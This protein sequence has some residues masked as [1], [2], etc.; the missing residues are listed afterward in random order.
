[1]LEHQEQFTMAKHPFTC[2]FRSV[3]NDWTGLQ[4]IYVKPE[5]WSSESGKLKSNSGEAKRINKLLEGFK[6]KA[7]DYQRELMTEGKE[8]T[9]ENMKAKWYKTS[10]EKPSMLKEIFRQHNEQMKALINQEFLH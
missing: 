3:L 9:V 7:F 8:V 2:E 5:E 6:M 10:L 1:M 4:K